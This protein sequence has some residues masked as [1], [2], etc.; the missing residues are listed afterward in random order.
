MNDTPIVERAFQL[1]REGLN[2]TALRTKLQRE[3][4]PALHI[5][6]HLS[7]FAIN[8]ALHQAARAARAQA[9]DGHSD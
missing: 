3:G 9:P 8:K 2:S 7:G 1:A 4:Y 5:A 6:M